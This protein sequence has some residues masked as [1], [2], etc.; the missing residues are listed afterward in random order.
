M[1]NKKKK[2]VYLPVLIITVIVVSFA[3]GWF[4]DYKNYISTDDAV[5]ESDVI[6][7]SSKSLGRVQKLYVEEGD[8]VQKGALLVELDSAGLMAEK[9]YAQAS[10]VNAEKSKLKLEAKYKYELDLYNNKEIAFNNAKKA[11]NKAS[12]QF[13]NNSITKEQYN[14][15]KKNFQLA[16]ADLADIEFV[17]NFSKAQ[18][19]NAVAMVESAKAKIGLIE[20]KIENTKIY[21][22]MDGIVAKRWMLPGDVTM[23]G[24]SIYTL[25]NHKKVWI[26]VYL[27]ETKFTQVR[28]NQNVK[29]TVDAYPGVTFLGKVIYTGSNT[30][31]QFSLIPPNNASGNYNKITQRLP[32]KISV[33]GIEKGANL[34]SY[35]LLSGMSV[36]V[37]IIKD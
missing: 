6:S 33:E 8:S 32:L 22:P 27:E 19:E 21:A 3:I 11:Y 15:A 9:R 35:K 29:F 25:S 26:K 24:Q 7:V 30:A 10:K 12:K 1:V 23:P 13:D 18:L 37:K 4:I 17:L 2:K 14:S 20:S 16:E 28:L 5:V 36:V 31:S 34:V